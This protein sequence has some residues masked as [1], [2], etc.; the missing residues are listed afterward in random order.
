[1]LGLSIIIILWI[2]YIPLLLDPFRVNGK[3]LI[4]YCMNLVVTKTRNKNLDSLKAVWD[5]VGLVDCALHNVS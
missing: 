3:Y 1:M 5:L 2:P 4:S